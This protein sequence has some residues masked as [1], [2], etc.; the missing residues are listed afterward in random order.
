MNA[1]MATDRCLD[2]TSALSRGLEQEA[3]D[4]SKLSISD[5]ELLD[6]FFQAGNVDEPPANS[7]D[8]LFQDYIELNEGNQS[9]PQVSA[10]EVLTESCSLAAH[11]Y[12]VSNVAN[13]AFYEVDPD[14]NR[15]HSPLPQ[16]DTSFEAANDQFSQFDTAF[17]ALSRCSD[18]S[19]S[20]H[21]FHESF[22]RLD[23]VPEDNVAS[24]PA[25]TCEGPS[26]GIPFSWESNTIPSTAA[27][28]LGEWDTIPAEAPQTEVAC[29]PQLGNSFPT[30]G[31]CPMS[32]SAP[33][34]IYTPS[35]DIRDILASQL[36]GIN[37]KRLQRPKSTA[38]GI[39]EEAPLRPIP[40]SQKRSIA[41]GIGMS[42]ANITQKSQSEL[43]AVHGINISQPNRRSSCNTNMR[44][45][46]RQASLVP[47]GSSSL[48]YTL[49]N[50]SHNSA[51]ETRLSKSSLANPSHTS[52]PL[53]IIQYQPRPGT[54]TL[55]PSSAPANT[56][57]QPKGRIGPLKLEQRREAAEMR[58]I[59]ACTNC[60]QRKAKCDSGTPC[61]SCLKRLG[62]ALL[63][64]HPCVHVR[65]PMSPSVK[66]SP[67][68]AS[69]DGRLDDIRLEPSTPL[70]EV[71]I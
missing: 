17:T 35:F 4:W 21:H 59:G 62:F 60:R 6:P 39:S 28:S 57:S 32:S 40:V 51:A 55:A 1:A 5:D 48:P 44:R 64:I 19:A 18:T 63:E 15:V 46:Q 29:L 52:T 61:Q 70:E 56:G 65:P 9:F 45:R 7:F 10:A 26:P 33:G 20:D 13:N 16:V 37:E 36:I 8:E 71:N 11:V 12:S 67:F 54:T 38:P 42:S 43:S 66:S 30:V 41:P 23:S 31:R 68:L 24:L 22:S 27:T 25:S 50:S 58:K 69:L 49:P 14:L 53:N 2:S 47:T 3:Q 34:P